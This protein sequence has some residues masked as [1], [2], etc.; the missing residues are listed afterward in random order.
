MQMRCPGRIKGLVIFNYY[1]LTNK[2]GIQE[3]KNYNFAIDV[4]KFEKNSVT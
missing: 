1:N 3:P 4:R 2:K